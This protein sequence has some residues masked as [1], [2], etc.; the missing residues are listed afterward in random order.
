MSKNGGRKGERFARGMA[1]L[2]QLSADAGKAVV[3]SLAD[4][5]AAL[6][7]GV[8]RGEIVAVIEQMAVY[9]GFPAA[10]NGVCAAKEVLAARLPDSSMV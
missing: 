8:T 6:K 9:A 4:I 2:E 1:A 5:G 3:A 7:A 10:L